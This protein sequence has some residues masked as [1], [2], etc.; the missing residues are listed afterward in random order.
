MADNFI[1]WNGGR[2]PPEWQNLLPVDFD[3]DVEPIVGEDGQV[4]IVRTM[5]GFWNETEYQ[6]RLGGFYD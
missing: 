6:L 3:Y 2:P 1:N 5:R 4:E